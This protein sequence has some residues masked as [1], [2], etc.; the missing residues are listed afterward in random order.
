MKDLLAVVLCGGQ[1]RRMGSDK[2]LLTTQNKPWAKVMAEKLEALSLPVVISINQG[3][4]SE[5]RKALPETTLIIDKTSIPGPLNG[6]LSIHNCYPEKDLLLMACDLI[7][8]DRETLSLLIQIYNEH[9][10]YDF[11][12]YK[13]AGFIQPFCA[14]YTAKGLAE[15]NISLGKNEI[16]KYGLHHRFAAGNTKFIFSTN[17]NAFNNYNSL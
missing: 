15:I 1:S 16:V 7:D 9:P 10:H 5:Y 11:Y 8:M 12:A 2:G 17:S 3:Q 14:I 13:L 6:L 4:L